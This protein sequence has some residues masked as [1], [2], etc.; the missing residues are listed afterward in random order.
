MTSFHL[1]C[2]LK[3]HL[4]KCSHILRYKG[5]SLACV[6]L[7]KG[8]SSAPPRSHLDGVRCVWMWIRG[9][10]GGSGDRTGVPSNAQLFKDL[11]F[12]PG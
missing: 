10:N 6:N 4:S 1:N 8:H 2:L 3:D 7:G 11:G 9:Q 12:S 5:L